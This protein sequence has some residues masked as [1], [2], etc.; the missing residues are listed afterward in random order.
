RDAVRVLRHSLVPTRRRPRLAAP[1]RARH[2]PGRPLP[3]CDHLQEP[4]HC[5]STTCGQV[6]GEL[7]GR[8]APS[9]SRWRVCLEAKR[10]SNVE[11]G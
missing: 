6:Q 8:R 5:A 3:P 10:P 2:R 4:H 9:G 7:S 11:G 1:P